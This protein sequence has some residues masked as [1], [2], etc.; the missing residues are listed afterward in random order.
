LHLIKATPRFSSIV[1]SNW[2]VIKTKLA[3]SPTALE[4]LQSFFIDNKRVSPLLIHLG[5]KELFRKHGDEGMKIWSAN[6][7][8]DPYQQ[9]Q[10]GGDETLLY[11]LELFANIGNANLR[12]LYSKSKLTARCLTC[13]AINAKE[14]ENWW[15]ALDTG[16]SVRFKQDLS[17]L[18]ATTP[19]FC[20]TST[21]GITLP[22]ADISIERWPLSDTEVLLINTNCT[23]GNWGRELQVPEI[24][25]GF[26]LHSVLNWIGDDIDNGHYSVY[27]CAKPPLPEGSRSSTRN[28]HSC[29]WYEINME[30][31]S[32]SS[33]YTPVGINTTASMLVYVKDVSLDASLDV[34]TE[35]ENT[36]K[37]RSNSQVDYFTVKTMTRISHKVTNASVASRP[38]EYCRTEFC[39][40][41]QSIYS[42]DSVYLKISQC[43]CRRRDC[44]NEG[45][46]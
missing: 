3:D 17:D 20:S 40:V 5:L 16:H 43:G 4:L 31:L 10:Y 18:R 24:L 19:V 36:P 27:V 28:N 32:K 7:M 35:I 42:D 37:K 12:F 1:T 2:S 29:S 30:S 22:S 9:E 14:A 33:R 38:M 39:D 23:T 8:E 13:R 46:L 15:W 26:R 25:G 34:Q 6:I 45:K 21:C 41:W 11:L 44:C